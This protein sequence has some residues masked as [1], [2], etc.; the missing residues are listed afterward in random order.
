MKKLTALIFVTLLL[1]TMACGLWS[2]SYAAVP[3][4]INYQGKLTSKGPTPLD[5][6][7]DHEITF[8]IYDVESGG[9]P[10]WEEI[11]P[12]VRIEKGIFAVMLGS[13]TDFKPKLSFDKDYY[14]EIKVEDDE[15]MAPRQRLASVGYALMAEKARSA[16]KADA[17]EGS[18]KASGGLVIETRTSDPSSPATGQIWLRTDL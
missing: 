12:D 10:L 2:I 1:W 17:A 11:H 5:E 3:Q 16:E 8:R 14:L 15:P 9:T 6:N 13:K 7:K 4:L 18:I